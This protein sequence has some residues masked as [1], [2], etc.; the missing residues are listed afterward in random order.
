MANKNTMN[1]NPNGSQGQGQENE[2]MVNVNEMHTKSE[3]DERIEKLRSNEAER[4][5]EIREEIGSVALDAVVLEY[6]QQ[7]IEQGRNISKEDTTKVEAFYDAITSNVHRKRARVLNKAR[8]ESKR[9]ALAEF[10]MRGDT[11]IKK[12][13]SN[14]R[15]AI[16]R[17]SLDYFKYITGID[18]DSDEAGQLHDMPDT[19][20]AEQPKSSEIDD[21]E[22]QT[23]ETRDQLWWS[24]NPG[25]FHPDKIK[26]IVPEFASL[27]PKEQ[28][29]VMEKARRTALTTYRE[30]L[31]SIGKP[32]IE[33]GKGQDRISD[34]EFKEWLS[35]SY[36]SETK[37]Y[38]SEK[39]AGN[40]LNE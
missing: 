8:M 7:K 32:W 38:I 11:N 20:Y 13:D 25:T 37:R 39:K 1:T 10:G 16:N 23:E 21:K 34:P 9:A 4:Q 33:S 40:N 18:Y 2:W 5:Q 35:Q 3:I 27:S 24:K 26:E 15:A 28:S 12:L 22:P 31:E 19:I 30:H 36:D 17:R 14:T 29:K 6:K